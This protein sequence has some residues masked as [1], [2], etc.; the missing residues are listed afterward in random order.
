MTA[1]AQA[2]VMGTPGPERQGPAGDSDEVSRRGG[3]S[4]IE[5]QIGDS[6]P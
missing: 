5:L 1:E 3:P 4:G 2:L 6:T